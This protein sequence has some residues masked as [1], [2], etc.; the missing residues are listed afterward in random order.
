MLQNSFAKWLKCSR[1]YVIIHLYDMIHIVRGG[2]MKNREKKKRIV[3]WILVIAM[4]LSIVG[5]ILLT[6]IAGVAS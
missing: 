5:G 3:A 1:E 2:I 6:A 4:G